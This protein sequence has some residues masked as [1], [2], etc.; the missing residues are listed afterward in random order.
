MHHGTKISNGIEVMVSEPRL[1]GHDISLWR[2]ERF[3]FEK[4]GFSLDE[5]EALLLYGPNGSGK[6]SLIRLIAGLLRPTSGAIHWN[7]TQISD[8]ETFWR[9]INYVGHIDAMKPL[10]TV[11]ENI[12][13]WSIFR[14]GRVNRDA[15]SHF[16]LQGIAHIPGRYL[17]SGQ[18]R[19]VELARLLA[20][21]TKL[22]LLDEPAV[23]LDAWAI[24]ALSSAISEHRAAGGLVVV[25]SH[26]DLEIEDVKT[27]TLQGTY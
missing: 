11:T 5:G 19:R 23:G 18:R 17:S 9:D 21:K 12:D 3:L 1:M 27:I 7:G 16:G 2:G 24:S 14:G 20:V 25:A 15:L 8:Q 10:L 4:L 13:F 26:G 6:T 22:W